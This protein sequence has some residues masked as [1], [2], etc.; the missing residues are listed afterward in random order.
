MLGLGSGSSPVMAD[1]DCRVVGAVGNKRIEIAGVVL[2]LL[3]NCIG[4]DGIEA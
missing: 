2:R 1:T 3:E 4:V